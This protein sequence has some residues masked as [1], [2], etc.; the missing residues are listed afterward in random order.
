MDGDSYP[1]CEPKVVRGDL[2]SDGQPDAAFFYTIE[3]F[4]Y[5]FDGA[6]VPGGA[7]ANIHSVILAALLNDR[8][9]WSIGAEEEVGGKGPVKQEGSVT[10]L[11][12]ADGELILDRLE[13]ADDDARCCP[14]I[15]TVARYRLER[16]SLVEMSR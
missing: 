13:Y 8:G 16:G 4:G 15:D 3:G 12:I 14:S 10:D 6:A 7:G 5:E 2:N 9:R 1:G 11:R